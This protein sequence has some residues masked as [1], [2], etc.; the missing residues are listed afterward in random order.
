MIAQST[1]DDDVRHLVYYDC[2]CRSFSA[3]AAVAAVVAAAAA[4]VAAIAA[5]VE[6]DTAV[7]DV[8]DCFFFAFFGVDIAVLLCPC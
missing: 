7:L 5:A 4:A 1:A 3:V 8:I 2:C 6:I